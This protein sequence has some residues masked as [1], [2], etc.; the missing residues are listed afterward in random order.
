MDLSAQFCTFYSFFV[1][2]VTDPFLI[3]PVQVLDSL[4]ILVSPCN[5]TCIAIK[6]LLTH[7]SMTISL[8]CITVIVSPSV[9][10]NTHIFLEG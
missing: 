10:I 4:D 2:L 1:R 3:C 9:L 6:M 7:V 8:N 5:T